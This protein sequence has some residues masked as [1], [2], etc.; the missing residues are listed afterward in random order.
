MKTFLCLFAV[1]S[2]LLFAS[3]GKRAE[4]YPV[5]GNV[6]CEG[7][8]AAGALVFFY[9]QGADPVSQPMIMGIAMQDGSFELSCGSQGKGAPPGSYDVV[10]QW[11]QRGGPNRRLTVMPDKLNGRYADPRHPLLH[12]KVEAEATQLPPFN[13]STSAVGPNP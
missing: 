10:I 9:R 5:S 7:R 6:T 3:C 4:I 8:P 11:K 13:L 1:I 2:P 12:A